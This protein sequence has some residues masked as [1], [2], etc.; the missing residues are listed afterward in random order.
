MTRTGYNALALTGYNSS[1]TA[2]NADLDGAQ[3]VTFTTVY[4]GGLFA[5]LSFYVPGVDLETWQ[6][7]QNSKLIAR[8]GLTTVWEGKVT[9]IEIAYQGDTAG[10]SVTC[11][12]YWASVLMRR[13]WR[14]WWADTRFSEDIWEVQASTGDVEEFFDVSREGAIHIMPKGLTF[15][16]GDY[17]ALRYTMPTG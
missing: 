9:G 15:T 6:L 14:K 1:G 10:V 8:N 3:D 4:P 17:I 7:A 16:S 5:A 13:G 11:L 12:G 2:L